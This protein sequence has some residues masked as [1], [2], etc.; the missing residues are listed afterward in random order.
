MPR[1]RG[2]LVRVVNRIVGEDGQPVPYEYMFG[3]EAG[4]IT[5]HV[6][7]PVDE[8]RV[9]I[10]NSMFRVDPVS[11]LPEYK[12]G[13]AAL[14]ANEAPIAADQTKRHELIQREL[15]SPDRQFGAKDRFGRTLKPVPFHNPINPRRD[16]SPIGPR[17]NEAGALPGEFGERL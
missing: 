14:G 2:P 11:N 8:A 5:D 6:D 16:A 15:L 1:H 17:P 12:L 3:G 4:W 9:V 7:L 10:H 13:C